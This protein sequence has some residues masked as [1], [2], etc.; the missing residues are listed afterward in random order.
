MCK[1]CEGKLEYAKIK[2]GWLYLEDEQLSDAVITFAVHYCPWC[3][4][5]LSDERM[6]PELNEVTR[7][8][9]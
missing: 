8:K 2:E 9:E 1:L 7:K 4:D 6:M 5:K 3:G